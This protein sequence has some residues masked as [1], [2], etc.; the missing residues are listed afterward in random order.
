MNYGEEILNYGLT[1]SS[2]VDFYLEN[3]TFIRGIYDYYY[4]NNN[5]GFTASNPIDPTDNEFQYSIVAG[6]IPVNYSLNDNKISGTASIELFSG[7]VTEASYPV[8]ETF[9]DVYYFI[10]ECKS[11][12]TQKISQ[13]LYYINL[14]KNW[15][16]IRNSFI[17]KIENQSFNINNTEMTGIEYVDYLTLTGDYL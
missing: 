17:S 2:E 4:N 6:Q 10:I 15:S 5:L 11:S 14:Y 13:K 7:T 8:W 12:K 3:T 9:Y 16:S 1:S